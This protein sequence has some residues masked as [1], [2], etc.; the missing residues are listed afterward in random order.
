MRGRSR[1]VHGACVV[2][3]MA[4]L[5]GFAIG[6]VSGRVCASCHVMSGRVRSCFVFLGSGAGF[7]DKRKNRTRRCEGLRFP[8]PP[9]SLEMLPCNTML[10]IPLHFSYYLFLSLF[11]SLCR[12]LL[13]LFLSNLFAICNTGIPH[14]SGQGGG[15]KKMA[16]SLPGVARF[17][18][19]PPRPRWR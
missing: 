7:C 16:G 6:S 17:F 1:R 13:V 18:F 12:S 8:Q 5:W 9:K 4:L 10:V 15:Q 14:V 11:P 19:S 3:G 2:L